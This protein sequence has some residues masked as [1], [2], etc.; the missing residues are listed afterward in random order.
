MSR[1]ARTAPS[2]QY[3]VLR[4][5]TSQHAESRDCSVIGVAAV[6]GISYAEAHALCAQ[7]GRKPRRGMRLYDICRAV[8]AAGFTTNT[9][10]TKEFVSRYPGSHKGLRNVTTHHP[11]RFPHVWRDGCTYLL[12][13]KTHVAAC[14][15]GTV[16][17]W[18]LNHALRVFKVVKI[19]KGA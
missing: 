12:F 16:H 8:N 18:A 10:P 2:E 19:E 11:A 3:A 14:V 4:T 7:Q 9:V 5:H 13:T 6:C 17:D 1:I 15:N